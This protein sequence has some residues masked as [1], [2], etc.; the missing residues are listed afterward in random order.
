MLAAYRPEV[1]ARRL[2]R[3]G[4]TLKPFVLL[5]LLESRKITTDTTLVCPR[6]LRLGGRDMDCVHAGTGS[7]L[8]PVEALAYSC[9]YY[10]ATFAARLS[11]QQL[12]QAL[13][14]AGFGSRTGLMPSEVTGVLV[15]PAT[16]EQRQLQALGEQNVRVTPLE[17]L[18][19]YRKL[20]L[21]QDEASANR[22]LATVFAGLEA[23]TAYGMARLA[24]P[25]GMRVAGKTGTAT[26][27]E[28]RWTHAW[29]VGYAPARHPTVALV[30]FLERGQG[31][32]DAARIADHIFAG[33]GQMR[34]TP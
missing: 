1:A 17:L 12:V 2:A 33:Y 6:K 7:A 23:A 10:F 3:P 26:A 27:D 22:A 19:A 14:Q 8:G 24:Q 34:G 9:N 5:A 21:R 30:V 16:T 32:S 18:A 15:Q 29:F 25:P 11:D 20:A 31:G 4:S 28:G 13:R